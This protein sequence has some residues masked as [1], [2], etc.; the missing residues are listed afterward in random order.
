MATRRPDMLEHALAQV[1]RQRGVERL[2]LVLAPHGFEPDLARVREPVGR[3][4]RVAGRARSR[5]TS[6]SATC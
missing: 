4:R 5:T 6:S 1:A 2:E 3:R